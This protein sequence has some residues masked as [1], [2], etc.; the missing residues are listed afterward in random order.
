MT[1][2]RGGRIPARGLALGVALSLA[3]AAAPAFAQPL[4]SGSGAGTGTGMSGGATRNTT[5]TGMSS[6]SGTS[7]T[8]TGFSSGAGPG[9]L[10]SNEMLLP[11]SRDN[12]RPQGRY[13]P[14]VGQRRGPARPGNRHVV[15]R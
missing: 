6:G 7:T 3:G 11:G 2:R 5:G 4:S 9:R 8:G 12:N 10:P 15:P 1:F 14:T 13:R